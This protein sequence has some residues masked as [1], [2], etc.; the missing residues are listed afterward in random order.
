M[1]VFLR[2]FGLLAVFVLSAFSPAFAADP[3]PLLDVDWLNTNLERD[4]L[5]L[6]DI[7]N[8]IDGGSAESFAKGHIPGSIHSDYLKAGW[9]TEVDGVVGQVPSA[10][11]LEALIGGLGIGND[12]TVLIIPAGVS[13]SDFGSAAR[14]YWTFKY[15]GHDQVAILDGGFRA[16]KADPDNPIETGVSKRDPEIFE[17]ELRPELRV[18]TDMVDAAIHDGK[19]I[20]LDGRP[21]KQFIGLE[22]HPASKAAGHIPGAIHFDQANSFDVKPA[23]LLIS[24]SSKV[25]CLKA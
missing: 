23:S 18:D 13:S 21:K 4:D 12:D 9:R 1:R 24:P 10:S 15:A 6:L 16:W 19:T 3:D 17:V 11:T 7:R 5:V 14:V 22:K 8:K 20:L 2:P 25:F